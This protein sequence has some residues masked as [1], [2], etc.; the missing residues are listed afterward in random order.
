MSTKI[1]QIIAREIL[2]SSG[3]PTVEGKVVLE[4]GTT[5]FCR[6]PSGA[7]IGVHEALELRDG[8]KNRYHGNGVLKAVKNANEKIAPILI[9]QDVLD[10]EKIDQQMI[11]LD[12]T[13][14][15]TNLGANATLAV[16][17]A[18]AQAAAASQKLP[19][20]KYLSQLYEFSGS[21]ILPKPMMVVIEGGKHAHESTDLQEFMI[22]PIGAPTIAEAIRWGEET[23]QSLKQILKD[24]GYLTN[25]GNEG[26]F[27]PSLNSNEEP[28][29]LIL[30]AIEQAGYK[31]GEDIAITLDPAASEVYKNGKYVLKKENRSLTA[32]EMIDY[33]ASWVK[34]Y[35]IT[36]IEDGLDQDDWDNWVKLNQRLGD[37]I[38]IMGDDLTVTNLKRISKAAEIKAINAVLI[39]FNQVGT[40]TETIKA[41]KLCQDYKFSYTISHRGGGET[42]DTAMIDIA[43]VTNAAFVKVGPTRGERT[44][45]YNHLM[46]I[47][48][49]LTK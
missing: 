19:L 35:P 13:E 4:D 31:P 49:E 43:V 37:Q 10:Q 42:E 9:G 25:V 48:L 6:V 26:A 29:E 40:L 24:K 39:K 44:M 38:T 34:K 46:G 36:I 45:K 27:A 20:Y 23:Y 30:Q 14:R 1:K 15:K 32:D 28:I 33:Y 21:F 7:S 3:T 18:C 12:G 41:V 11:D 47:E 22:A 8:D 17:S 2:D 16:S 5:G